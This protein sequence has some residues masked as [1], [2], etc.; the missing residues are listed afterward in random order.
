MNI[1]I[2]HIL[3]FL[4]ETVYIIHFPFKIVN[5]LLY[6]AVLSLAK[7]CPN[8]I[9]FYFPTLWLLHLL[10]ESSYLSNLF[11]VK[12][13]CCENSTHNQW[14]I[15]TL[16]DFANDDTNFSCLRHRV[17]G[18]FTFIKSSLIWQI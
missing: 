12:S 4:L 10:G 14:I 3:H 16:T 11:R 18:F 5:L 7:V 1:V 6:R 15:T 9:P 8:L 13:D 2:H 17:C